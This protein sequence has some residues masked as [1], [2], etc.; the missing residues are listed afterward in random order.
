[1][2]T[3][4]SPSIDL[5]GKLAAT[6]VVSPFTT[7]ATGHFVKPAATAQPV[8][9]HE[10]LVSFAGA[11]TDMYVGQAL[12]LDYDEPNAVVESVEM[13]FVAMGNPVQ[14]IDIK[15]IAKP[16]VSAQA[17]DAPATDPLERNAA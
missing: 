1:M 10:E 5:N 2:S 11:Y 6:Q 9:Q 14:A 12:D 16:R 15:V 13:E 7:F 8:A 17:I 3:L 4:L